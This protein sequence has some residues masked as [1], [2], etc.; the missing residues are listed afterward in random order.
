MKKKRMYVMYMKHRLVSQYPK[1]I[2][3][4]TPMDNKIYRCSRP[5]YKMAHTVSADNL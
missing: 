4:R 5:L 2:I 3:S 1:G